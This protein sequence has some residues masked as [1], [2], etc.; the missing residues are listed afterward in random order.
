MHDRMPASGDPA[1]DAL[2]AEIFDLYGRTH[3]LSLELVGPM[4]VPPDLTMQQ[5]RVLGLVAGEPGLTVQALGH[6]LAVSTPTASGLVERLVDKGLLE[7]VDDE[8][9]R[10]VRRLRMTAEGAAV[11]G[12]MDSMFARVMRVVFS[13]LSTEELEQFRRTSY[14]LLDAMARALASPEL[15]D[16]AHLNP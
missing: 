13:L 5:V 14:L 10:R 7:R 12:R 15:R 8:S 6:T 4:P 3:S 11:L 2:V 1:R 16:A 9:D